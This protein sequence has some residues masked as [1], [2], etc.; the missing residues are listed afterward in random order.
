[1]IFQHSQPVHQLKLPQPSLL[2]ADAIAFLLVSSTIAF[3][4]L[5][6]NCFTSCRPHTRAD[7]LI[8]LL[9]SPLLGC[10]VLTDSELFSAECSFCLSLQYVLG[11]EFQIP[12]QLIHNFFSTA[13]LISVCL[14]AFI[15]LHCSASQQM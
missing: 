7:G 1:V 5:T 9:H 10:T 3:F 8:H 6:A 12:S 11:Q 13:N 15:S 14:S 2:P 4:L